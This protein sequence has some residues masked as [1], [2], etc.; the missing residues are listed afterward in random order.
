MG[1]FKKMSKLTA[2][3]LSL[4]LAL[5][6]FGTFSSLNT[7]E[8]YTASAASSQEGELYEY[9]L[10]VY[11]VDVRIGEE[12]IDMTVAPKVYDMYEPYYNRFSVEISNP[13]HGKKYMDT[14]EAE[15]MWAKTCGFAKLLRN[16]ITVNM[17][18][19]SAD[20][21]TSSRTSDNGTDLPFDRECTYEFC[22]IEALSSPYIQ[23]YGDINSDGVVD[24]FDTVIYRMEIAGTNTAAL[25][26]TQKLNA[27]INRDDVIN[28]E[29]LEQVMDF[30]LGRTKEFNSVGSLRSVDLCAEIG[31]DL[32]DGK[33]T[34]EKFASAEMNLG[35]NLL[36]ECFDPKKEDTKNTLLS[37]LSISAALAMTANGADGKTLEEMEKVIGNGLTIDEINDYMAYYIANLPDGEREKL[38]LADSIWF[39]D[40]PKF[41]VYEDFL[42]KNVEY[43]D[44]Q[45]YK[46][47]F[48]DSTVKDVNSWVN[49]NTRGMIPSLLKKGDLDPTDE[50]IMM[51]MLI[52]TLYFENDWAEPYYSTT[53]G[54]FTD[55][56]GVEHMI[57]R[58][59]SKEAHYYDLGDADAFDKEFAGGSYKFVGIMPKEKDIVEYVNDLDAEKLFEGLS[60]Y[61]DP[62]TVDLYVM[63]PKFK[64]NYNTS[65]KEILPKLGMESAFD[66]RLA[67]FSKINDLSIEGAPALYIDDVLHKTRI[68]VTEK[69]VKAAAVTAVMMAAGCAMPVPKKEVHI[70]LDKPFVYMILDKNNV[71][72]FIGAA[73][74]LE[75][76]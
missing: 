65:F 72:L 3:V 25:T 53:E 45:L 40:D 74:Q 58:M 71:P 70:E 42:K 67:D 55:Y 76:E 17:T 32:S 73:S 22:G 47:P 14:E 27:D 24:T 51:M 35:V 16:E 56:D 33:E 39:R 52:N 57:E 18:L 46:A 44:A 38:Y 13:M 49:D 34:D 7:A 68:E 66:P 23:F 43:Y 2:G 62:E 15:A 41:A 28:E 1:M 30:V 63:I 21:Y 60:E 75:K 5:G 19:V 37:P 59:D 26:E 6:T 69:G 12:Y 8:K 54:T 50:K 29:D 9:D 10:D 20:E 11:I 48:D 4:S 36:K 64:Y 61:E 31:G